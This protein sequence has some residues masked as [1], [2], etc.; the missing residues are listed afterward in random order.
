MFGGIERMENYLSSQCISKDF[1][2]YVQLR[3][4]PSLAVFSLGPIKGSSIPN[5]YLDIR[6]TPGPEENLPQ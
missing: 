5:G 6:R 1:I 3:H 4:F 2:G